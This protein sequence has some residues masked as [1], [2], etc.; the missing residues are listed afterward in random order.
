MNPPP[1][2]THCEKLSIK[3]NNNKNVNENANQMNTFNQKIFSD[4]VT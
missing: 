4:S 1:L 3:F 2:A